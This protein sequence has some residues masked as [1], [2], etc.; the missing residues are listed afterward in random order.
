MSTGAVTGRR[1]SGTDVAAAADPVSRVVLRFWR[2]RVG[3]FSWPGG[4]LTV[5]RPRYSHEFSEITRLEVRP[6]I[7]I[8][9]LGMYSPCSG[10][11]SVY[12]YGSHPGAAVTAARF[13]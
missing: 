4:L 12:T 3:F 6:I 7:Y 13:R 9:S 1:G 5:V 8:M 11:L 2:V 10:A